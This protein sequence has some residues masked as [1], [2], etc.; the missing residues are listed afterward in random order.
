MVPLDHD[1]AGLIIDDNLFKALV[2]KISND[3]LLMRLMDS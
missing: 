3:V 1:A 2:M